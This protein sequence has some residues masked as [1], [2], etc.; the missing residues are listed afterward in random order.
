MKKIIRILRRAFYKIINFFRNLFRHDGPSKLET[1]AKEEVRRAIKY[2][3]LDA[4]SEDP[5]AR[6]AIACYNSA[7]K[8]LVSLAEDRHSGM[9]IQ[10]TKHILTRLIDWK[11]L[12]PVWDAPGEWSDIVDKHDAP[13]VNFQHK[14]YGSLF[15]HGNLS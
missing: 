10:Y 4:K 1:W 12:T 14:R 2:E 15:K 13:I 9:S 11:P 7:L 8:A 5:M 6:Y 3:K